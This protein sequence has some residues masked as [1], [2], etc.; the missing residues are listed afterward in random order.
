MAI[1]LEVLPAADESVRCADF[2]RGLQVDPGGSAIRA[3]LMVAV[4]TPLPWPKPVFQHVA[5]LGLDAVMASAPQPTRIL[6]AVPLGRSG[7]DVLSVVSYER[8]ADPLDPPQRREW[9]TDVASLADTVRAVVN[10]TEVLG[11]DEVVLDEPAG[12]EIWICTQGTH[13]LCCGADGMRLAQAVSAAWGGVTVRRVSHTG[14]HRFAPTALTL[15]DGRMWAYADIDALDAVVTR[16]SVTTGLADR[17]RGWWGVETGGAQVAERAVWARF[18]W[19][20]PGGSVA[21]VRA[22]DGV[23]TYA[24]TGRTTDG[25]ARSFEVDVAI[26]REVP[27]ITCRAPGGLPAKPGREFHVHD[28]RG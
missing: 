18:G 1:G 4:E 20:W 9:H 26:G 14:G 25:T 6:A 10:G 3:D 16:S 19:D 28:V 7:S 5:L 8:A 22:V 17:C 2:T 27:S 12:P 23:V 24:V 21:E 13:D 15:P 11:A